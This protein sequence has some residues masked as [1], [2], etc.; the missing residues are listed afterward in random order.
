MK[1]H[2]GGRTLNIGLIGG[3][4][5]ATFLL[6][7]IEQKDIKEIYIRS[8]LVRDLQKY[9][10]LE[11]YG[12]TLYT[13]VEEFL[14]SQIDLVVET[15]TVE[16]VREI[17]PTVLKKKDV[18]LISI[19]ALVDDDFLQEL[20]AIA[21]L[22]KRSL[23]LPSGAIGGLDLLQNANALNGVERVTLT[24]RKPAHTLT[25]EP[26]TGE[27]VIF[28]GSAREAIA[29]FPKNVNVA[30]VLSLAGIGMDKTEVQVVAD[31]NTNK[32]AHTIVTKGVFGSSEMTV[33][34]E[35]LP[36]NPSTSYL[37]AMSVLSTCLSQSKMVCIG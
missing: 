18:I 6:E 23:Y 14:D 33:T 27:K 29:K 17:I 5:I 9:A 19:G 16:A 34:N 13:D 28:S 35:P 31:P 26:L 36:S 32:N 37:A 8:V 4:A 11:K 1:E 10:H 3:G 15:A 2:R 20:K 12:I 22:H 24:T 7:E 25:D 30:I 21:K